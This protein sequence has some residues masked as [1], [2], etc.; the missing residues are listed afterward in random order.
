M[1]SKDDLHNRNRIMLI[2]QLYSNILLK[3]FP[4]ME[5]GSSS[6][7]LFG[8]KHIFNFQGLMIFLSKLR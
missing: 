5:E 7:A 6:N 3:L 1:I 2:R 8:K 4:Q